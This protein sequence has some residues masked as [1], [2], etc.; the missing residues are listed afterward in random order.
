MDRQKVAGIGN[1]LRHEYQDVAA[2][3]L[4]HVVRDNL[5]QL[6]TACRTELTR[7]TDG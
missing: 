2:D 3:V 1:V 6:E 4:W 5:S 7:Q